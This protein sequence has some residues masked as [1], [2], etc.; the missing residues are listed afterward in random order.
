MNDERKRVDSTKKQSEKPRGNN[1][2]PDGSD[3]KSKRPL[4]WDA[5]DLKTYGWIPKSPRS[6]EGRYQDRYFE[7][8]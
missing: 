2:S 8:E 5:R 1:S 4:D 6:T 3:S 7:D